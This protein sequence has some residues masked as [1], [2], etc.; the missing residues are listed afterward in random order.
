MLPELRQ[1]PS[2]AAGASAFPSVGALHA[3]PIHPGSLEQP[4][5]KDRMKIFKYPLEILDERYVLMPDGAEIISAQVQHGT[6]CLWAIVED[7]RQKSRRLIE[8]FGTGHAIPNA[9]RRFIGT[10]QMAGVA[11]VWHVFEKL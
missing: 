10:V 9:D 7:G 1:A 8:I 3:L 5:T 2:A 4:Q 6:L 11:L